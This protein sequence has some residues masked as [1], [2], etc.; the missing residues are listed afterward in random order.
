MRLIHKPL[1]QQTIVI[2]GASSGI[3]LAT[4]RMAAE[5]GANVVV[6]ARTADALAD[7]VGEIEGK[8]GRAASVVADVGKKADIE[9]IVHTAAMTFGGFDTWVNVAGQTIYGHLW[10]VSDTDHE[11]LVQTNFWGTVYGSLAA[12]DHL[13]AKG[14]ALINVG[15]IASDFALPMQGMYSATKH[16]IKGFT[17]AL[18]MELLKEGVP[19]SVTLIKPTSIDSPLPQRARNYMAHEPALPPPTYKPEEVGRAILHA[20]VTPQRDIYVGG[21]GRLL[22]LLNQMAPSLY[23]LLAP[24][25]TATEHT[26][27]EPEHTEGTLHAPE[28]A[29]TTRGRS[30]IVMPASLY[31]RANTHPLAPGVIVAAGVSALSRLISRGRGTAA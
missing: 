11:R 22:V 9:Q 13:R 29:G 27:E 4:A 17:D 14:G 7:L 20:A 18:R 8:G 15:S 25:V 23:D 19:I 28:G 2:T 3:G 5:Q 12:V 24:A 21:V 1:R 10:D 30:S 31:T 16:A 6:A 26:N